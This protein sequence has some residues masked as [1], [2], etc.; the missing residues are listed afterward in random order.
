[1]N[2]QPV[3]ILVVVAVSQLN[4]VTTE[5]EKGSGRTLIELGLVGPKKLTNVTEGFKPRRKGIQSI[6]WNYY[7]VA[8]NK[9]EPEL[10]EEFVLSVVCAH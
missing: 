10:S 6:F 1:V 4:L 9:N 3:P 7:H 2:P 5:V 8:G